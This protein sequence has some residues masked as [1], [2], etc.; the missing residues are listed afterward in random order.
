MRSRPPDGVPI[1]ATQAEV[2]VVADELFEKGLEVRV[3]VKG[4]L[5]SGVTVNEIREVLLHAT[6]YCGTPAGRQA[7]L[8]AHETLVAEGAVPTSP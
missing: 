8:A 4:A 1:P 6:V 5:R 2:A 7:F 3:Y